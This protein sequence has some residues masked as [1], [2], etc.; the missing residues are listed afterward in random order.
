MSEQLCLTWNNYVTHMMNGFR[1]LLVNQSMVDVTLACDGLS[2][3]AHKVVLSACSPLFQT[4]FLEN[5][6]QHPIVILKD[7]KYTDMKALLDIMYFGKVY[8]SDNQLLNLKKTAEILRVKG[9][10][11]M[12]AEKMSDESSQQSV[13]GP[14]RLPSKRRKHKSKKA[15]LNG[16]SDGRASQ[17]ANRDADAD[18][19]YNFKIPLNIGAN[20]SYTPEE[21]N[22]SI[23]STIKSLE[24]SY[25]DNVSIILNL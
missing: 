12:I 24:E 13:F 18:E 20:K 5:P 19:V 17:L 2:L 16:R 14:D 9:V 8:I 1:H 23:V 11:E 22:L 10:V 7:V 15:S 21:S 6:C 3:K 25:K 4:L